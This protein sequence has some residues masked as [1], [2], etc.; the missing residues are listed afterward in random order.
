MKENTSIDPSKTERSGKLNALI[1]PK[2]AVNESIDRKAIQAPNNIDAPI[3]E[4]L[5]IIVLLNERPQGNAAP[6]TVIKNIAPSLII[7]RILDSGLL[8]SRNIKIT[9]AAITAINE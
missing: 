6:A 5:L 1:I 9:I 7:S 2:I 8:L 4:L 3:L